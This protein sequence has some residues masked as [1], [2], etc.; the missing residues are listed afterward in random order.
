MLV[1]PVAAL[2]LVV[3]HAVWNDSTGILLYASC[4]SVLLVSGFLALAFFVVLMSRRDQ[5]P[6]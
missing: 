5:P 6:R 2:A 3:W 1:V 4:C